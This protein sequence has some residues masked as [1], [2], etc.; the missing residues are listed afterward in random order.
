MNKQETI[1]SR[2]LVNCQHCGKPTNFASALGPFL[3]YSAD[4]RDALVQACGYGKAHLHL[5]IQVLDSLFIKTGEALIPQCAG[6][7]RALLRLCHVATN[8]VTEELTQIGA[9]RMIPAKE[10]YPKLCRLAMY[11]NREGLKELIEEI[12]HNAQDVLLEKGKSP[13]RNH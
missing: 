11:G 9:R 8:D 1:D 6:E 13:L 10:W 7:C 12:Q 2:T 3:N 5:T 4:E